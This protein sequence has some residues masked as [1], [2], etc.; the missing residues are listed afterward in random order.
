MSEADARSR[1]LPGSFNGFLAESRNSES[2]PIVV[3]SAF[4]QN[5]TMNET[6]ILEKLRRN[7]RALL[8]LS[9]V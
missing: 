4:G 6:E 5:D 1:Y 9:V 7:V 3:I 2:D 8:M